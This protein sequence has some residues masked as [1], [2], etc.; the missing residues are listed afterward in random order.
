M[1]RLTTLTASFLLGVALVPA[2]VT[3][4]TSGVQY[5]R[6]GLLSGNHV[7]TVL[8]NWGVIAQPVDT[9]PRGAWM[10]PTN[11][12]IGDMSIFVGIELPIRDYT[13]DSLPD[14]VHTVITC[15]VSRPALT[16]DQDPITGAWWT[17][18][19]EGGFFAP[20][21]SSVATREGPRTWPAVWPDHPE[22]GSGV[23]NGLYGPNSY[24][25]DHDIFFRMNDENDLRFNFVENN[26]RGIVFHPDTNNVARTGQGIRVDV[27][28]IVV[29]SLSFNDVLFRVFDITNESSWRYEK[30]VFGCLDGTYVG[31]TGNDDSPREYDDDVSVFYRSQNLVLVWDF[32]NDNSRNPL[33]QGPVG[34]FAETYLEAP[35]SNA[36]ASYYSVSPSGQVR[37]G[38]D[39]WLWQALRPGVFVNPPTV[40]NDT[41]A[42]AGG[43]NDYI[44]GTNYFSLNPGETRR[45]VSII[46]YGYT[47]EDVNKNILNARMLWN[48]G[49]DQNIVKQGA[50]ITNFTNHR[51]VSGVQPIEWTSLF[52]GGTVDI[53]FSPDDGG[54]WSQIASKLP[55]TAV[56]EN[57][58]AGTF[59]WNTTGVSDCA[60]GILRIIANDATGA[61]YGS[62]VT[63]PF[64]I[65]NPGNGPPFFKI[66]NDSL[67]SA[68]VITVPTVDL[69]VLIGDPEGNAISVTS[70]YRTETGG[71]WTAFDTTAAVADT[72]TQVW[73]TRVADLPNSD[74]FELKYVATDG[75]LISAD[76]TAFFRKQTPHALVPPTNANHTAG[77]AEVPMEV[78]V[79]SPGLVRPDRYIV[80]FDDT[81]KIGELRFSVY[82]QTSAIQ[83]L[84]GVQLHSGI[85]SQ[86]FDG[87][88]LYTP[89]IQTRFDAA[90][91]HWSIAPPTGRDF[92][93]DRTDLPFIPLIGYARPADYAV[94]F[95]SVP[96]DTSLALG[97]DFTAEP[98]PFSAR[99]MLTGQKVRFLVTRIPG[100]DELIF[101]EQ[102]G[103]ALRPTWDLIL[104]YNPPTLAPGKGD[105]LYLFTQKA[106][107]IHDTLIVSDF[108]VNV[109]EHSERPDAFVLHQNYPNPFNPTT[110]VSFQL[111]VVSDVRLVVYDLL[112]REVA[113]LVNEMKAPGSYEV[114]FDATGLASGV[115]FYRLT[116]RPTDSGQAGTFVQTRKMVV[117]K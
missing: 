29:D 76:S 96:V 117:V 42:I 19:P 80:T 67:A 22:W 11:G 75:L 79:V 24:V 104:Q 37:L 89:Q 41:V 90:R 18:Q 57:R 48:A 92:A 84:L 12:Y 16:A 17:F 63:P 43:D 88:G 10:Y 109:K 61:P 108:M 93:M 36:I 65:N 101:M 39:E 31:I 56:S 25:G 58:I 91:S 115:Y 113:V 51:E 9:R 74:S 1:N 20:E 82:D 33:W 21:Q 34:R 110:A 99:D 15:P 5:Q 44:S 54:T 4:Q 116:A 66:L 94:A 28:Y 72:S 107:S 103:D 40:I 3:A 97:P 105:T 59:D 87:L 38:D 32:P 95:D 23:W 26:P 77:H 98:V 35:G 73:T 71:V 111:P 60:F 86:P 49:F 100:L 114:R 102:V 83:K 8:G 106:Y 70:Y 52:P 7:F 6:S 81:T 50:Q 112:G 78:R 45:I 30:V 47:R 85:E 53:L 62:S 64:T 27:R 68:G 46:A 55:T 69:S 13:G 2:I 14:T